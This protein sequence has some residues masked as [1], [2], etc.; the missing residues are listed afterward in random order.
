ML[1]SKNAGDGQG[2]IDASVVN[3]F[4]AQINGRAPVVAYQCII[5]KNSATFDLVYAS[6][7]IEL[8][9][10]FYGTDQRGDPVRFEFD[11]PSNDPLESVHT[12]IANGYINGYKYV[13]ALW[14]NLDPA[15]YGAGCIESYETVFYAKSAPT[16]TIDSNFTSE[17]TE[18]SLPLVE[19]HA[20][21]WT[22]V[23]TQANNVGLMWFQWRLALAS[24][25]TH[26]VDQTSQL[27]ASSRLI[28]THEGLVSGTNY[29]I[30]I[31]AQNADGVLFAS[32]W[33]DFAA[34]Y[35]A[36]T[37]SSVVKI[38]LT[39]DNG[40]KVDMGDIKYIEGVPN[41]GDY[42]YL[43]PLPTD[44]HTC[45]ELLAGNVITF[46]SSVHFAFETPL[47]SDLIWSANIDG[48]YAAL[49]RADGTD[50]NEES[51]YIELS[52]AGS[53]P[54]LQPSEDL[55]PSETLYPKADNG[56]YFVLDVNGEDSFTV[57][58]QDYYPSYHWFVVRMN[59]TGMAVYAAEI[60]PQLILDADVIT[61]A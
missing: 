9:E 8:P 54:G 10:P 7:I 19:S 56:G 51:Y 52:H 17:F 23:Y 58:T 53:E 44:G 41:N 20:C 24:D 13:L 4:S 35:N 61:P 27:R 16:I 14:W 33:V 48:D 37:V 1:P 12:D 5:F 59:R 32:E 15:D 40:V 6:G 31:L 36:G 34:L 26:I 30:M 18:E 22:A 49:Y 57:S 46:E 45:V 55:Y 42:R 43:T 39:N 21:T 3:T 25:H 2:V 50:E 29:S 47:D 28:Y 38:T 60:D 11:V